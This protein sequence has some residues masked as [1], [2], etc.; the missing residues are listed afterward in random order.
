MQ[1]M[2]SDDLVFT[3]EVKEL[4]VLETSA[5]RKS[6]FCASPTSVMIKPSGT[7]D[8]IGESAFRKVI[9]HAY[10]VY[11]IIFLGAILMFDQSVSLK[12]GANYFVF[13]PVKCI[14]ESLNSL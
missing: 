8:P 13:A 12:V 6:W 5:Q 4:R 9:V 10:W 3:N 11:R 2:R 7:L 1:M 14:F